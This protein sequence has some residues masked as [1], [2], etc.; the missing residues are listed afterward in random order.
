MRRLAGRW[1]HLLGHL[2]T[3]A[4]RNGM[5]ALLA[6]YLPWAADNGAFAGFDPAAF[7]RLLRKVA[8][9]PRCLFVACPDVVGDHAGTLARFREWS[10]EVRGCGQPVAFV[11]QD[12]AEAGP[13][14]WDDFDAWFVGGGTAWKL[15]AA[16]ADLCRE[17]RR[18]G[19]WVH[20]GRVNSRRR[21][22]VAH[23]FGAHSVDGSSASMY[24]DKYIHKYCAWLGHIEAQGRLF[25]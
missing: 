24:G 5:A 12:G 14:P 13:V 19:K 20:V 21:M 22:E 16:S 25:A 9:R 6:T 4:N 17:A 1:P 23:R 2:L 10:G 7:R 8:G 15:S 18:R 3:P 11:G